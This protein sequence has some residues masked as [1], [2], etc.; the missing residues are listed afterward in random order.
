[1]YAMFAK[2]TCDHVYQ[3]L[4]HRVTSYRLP[5]QI[6]VYTVGATIATSLYVYMWRSQIWHYIFY[7]NFNKVLISNW[8]I[9]M[10]F[11][12]KEIW[13]LIGRDSAST[14]SVLVRCCKSMAQP[15]DAIM[16]H[17]TYIVQ[18]LHMDATTPVLY[19]SY[20][21]PN[22]VIHRTG[23][24]PAIIYDD[25]M[26]VYIKMGVIH[27]DN[28]QP[29]VTTFDTHIGMNGFPAPSDKKL[30]QNANIWFDHGQ[31]HRSTRDLVTGHVLPAGISDKIMMWYE[32]GKR[33]RDD[34]DSEG[35][36]LPAVIYADGTQKWYIHNKLHRN[37]DLPS[38][39][40][41]DGNMK[42][43]YQDKVHRDTRDPLTGYTLPACVYVDGDQL[44]F[45][46]GQWHRDDRDPIT[47]YLLP[48]KIRVDGS[49]EWYQRDKRHRDDRDADD[50]L[51][52]A[53]IGA[54]G[55][56]QWYINGVWYDK[57]GNI[58]W[59]RS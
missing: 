3:R 23:D 56:S 13:D 25:G 43:Y 52:P 19:K 14:Y 30:L 18:R 16:D 20:H 17:F 31:I 21:L 38:I 40:D 54:T 37:E 28:D 7:L 53:T 51:L 2:M 45:Q 32:Y 12:P 6:A 39:I 24:R 1:M 15:M 9:V 44:W 33:H 47:G 10:S 26:T 59:P 42:W 11:L 57:E 46:H 50:H 5:F 48:A 22:K 4:E 27:R 29:A 58:I 41:S 35:N 55:Y 49:Q 34:R 8:P 36:T